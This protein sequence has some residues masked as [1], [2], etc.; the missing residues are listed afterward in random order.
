MK[1]FSKKITAFILSSLVLIIA[2]CFYSC[3]TKETNVPGQT[4]NKQYKALIF[5]I[6]GVLLTEPYT[7]AQVVMFLHKIPTALRHW[8]FWNTILNFKQE[9][10]AILAPEARDTWENILRGVPEDIVA[11]QAIEYAQHKLHKDQLASITTQDLL[12]VFNYTRKYTK[13]SNAGLAL[14]R[15]AKEKGYKV[16]LLSNIGKEHLEHHLQ[17]KDLRVIFDIADG[18]VY[19][20]EVGAIKPEPAIYQVL[21]NKYNL[22]PEECLFFDNHQEMIDGA[23]AVGIDGILYR[24]HDKVVHE[25]KRRKIL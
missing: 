9:R 14:M 21:L 3:R 24:N 7:K 17:R 6:G 5:D 10:N 11:Q 22:R 4:S 16:Y 23:K 20:Y 2:L 13:I 12:N 8:H 1:L 15:K 18:A 19:S 25:L